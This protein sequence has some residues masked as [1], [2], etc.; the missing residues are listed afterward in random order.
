MLAWRYAFRGYQT[1][2]CRVKGVPIGLAFLP[3]NPV[4]R[5]LL[6]LRAFNPYTPNGIKF[7]SSWPSSKPRVRFPI[8]PF[9][10]G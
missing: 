6:Q 1:P 4:L 2:A 3:L 8:N 5:T 9:R 10:H 7:A